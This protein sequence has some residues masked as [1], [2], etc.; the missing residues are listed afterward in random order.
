MEMTV[1]K[2]LKSMAEAG[3]NGSFRATNGELTY[4]GTIDNGKISTVKVQTVAESRAKIGEILN[5]N[6]ANKA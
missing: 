4:R 3:F 6:K 2:F 1:N 5:A